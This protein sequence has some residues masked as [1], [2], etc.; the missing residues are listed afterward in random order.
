ML[1]RSKRKKEIASV[2]VDDPAV[3]ASKKSKSSSPSQATAPTT[4]AASTDVAMPDAPVLSAKDQADVKKSVAAA[5]R[6][7]SKAAHQAEHEEA[8]RARCF[9][10]EARVMKAAAPTT[11][12]STV[13]ARL[14]YRRADAPLLLQGDYVRV[15]PDRTVGHNCPGG[16]GWVTSTTGT[17]A[18]LTACVN[19]CAMAGGSKNVPLRRIVRVPLF[20]KPPVRQCRQRAAKRARAETAAIAPA[21]VVVVVPI[22]VR[23]LLAKRGGKA[24]GWRRVQV[25]GKGGGRLSYDQKLLCGAECK[26]LLAFL[27]GIKA[28]GGYPAARL[29]LSKQRNDTG[30]FDLVQLE[31]ASKWGGTKPLT[32]EYLA[33]AWGVSRQSLNDYIARHTV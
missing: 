2:V 1:R 16:L 23:L 9:A 22:H 11:N 29:Q 17:G 26:A 27:A 28:G 20:P 18:T 13:H 32:K 8:N 31:E 25:C 24:K 21:P 5:R 15:D 30:G 12:L 3:P 19:W 6:E 33:D 4:I 14:P 10:T 7:A